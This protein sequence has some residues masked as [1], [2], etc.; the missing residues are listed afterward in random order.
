MEKFLKKKLA[1]TSPKRNLHNRLIYGKIAIH[2]KSKHHKMGVRGYPARR[3]RI[4]TKGLPLFKKPENAVFKFRKYD[5]GKNFSA[6]KI[7]SRIGI[8]RESGKIFFRLPA[9]QSKTHYP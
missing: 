1:K 7:F 8:V 2:K 5:V 6:E 9:K 4:K 3:N